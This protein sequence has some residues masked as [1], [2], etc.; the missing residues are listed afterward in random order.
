MD[1]TEVPCFSSGSESLT[2]SVCLLEVDVIFVLSQGLTGLCLFIMTAHNDHYPV[3]SGFRL[4]APLGDSAEQSI[5]G[6]MAPLQ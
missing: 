4:L 5:C 1:K 6:I 3:P 2:I